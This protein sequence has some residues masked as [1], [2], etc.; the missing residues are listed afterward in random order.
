MYP[1]VFVVLS[2][3]NSIA[4]SGFDEATGVM[5]SRTTALVWVGIAIVL[6]MARVGGLAYSYVLLRCS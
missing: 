3:L 6:A 4:R 2:T 5:D 1:C